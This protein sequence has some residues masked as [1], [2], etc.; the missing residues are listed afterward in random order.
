MNMGGKLGPSG[1]RLMLGM[2]GQAVHQNG[3]HPERMRRLK[4]VRQVI[5]HRC[6]TWN[7]A[8]RAHEALIGLARRLGVD[9][10]QRMNVED[11]GESAINAEPGC[12]RLSMLA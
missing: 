7:D 11:I 3:G 12:Y 8:A 6:L 9:V 5:E 2:V 4:I 1:D 10:F